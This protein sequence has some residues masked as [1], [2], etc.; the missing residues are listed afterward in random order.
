MVH[1]KMYLNTQPFTFA[2]FLFHIKVKQT[3]FRF[4]LTQDAIWSIKCQKN[5]YFSKEYSRK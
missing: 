5:H 1:A 2:G 3:S 4:G